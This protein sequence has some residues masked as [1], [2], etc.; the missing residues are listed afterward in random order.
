MATGL[1][2]TNLA[3]AILNHLR[4]G[5]SWTQPAAIYVKLHTGD[6]GSAATAN[7]SAVT[8]R[9]QVNFAAASGGAIALTGTAP[10]WTASATE[11]ISHL[12]F[13]DA[14][15]AGNVL[16]SSQLA[17]PRSVVSGDTMT[18]NTCT[19]SLAPVMA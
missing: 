10:Q 14:A 8:T 16:C 1:N 17:T 15:T 9:L 12:S 6:P 13:W 4:G 18:L 7:A 19:I 2:G 5:T 11:T 3:N